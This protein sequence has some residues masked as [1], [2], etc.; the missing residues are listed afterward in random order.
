MAKKP[1]VLPKLSFVDIVM[2]ADADV[3]KA[4]YDARV[5]IDDLLVEREEAYRRIEQLETQ[6]ESVVGE[7]G[8]FVFPPPPCPVAG[9]DSAGPATRPVPKPEPAVQEEVPKPSGENVPEPSAES[10]E[11][12]DKPAEPV[13]ETPAEEAGAAAA[14]A[15]SGDDAK[16]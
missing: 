14:E 6:I 13:E 8:V 1:K 11:A 3:I 2:R 5:K 7:P 4:A 10:A 9:L 12:Q 15:D 16:A